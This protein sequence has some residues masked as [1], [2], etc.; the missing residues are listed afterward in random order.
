MLEKSESCTG[1]RG[2][3]K[4]RESKYKR[5]DLGQTMAVAM[6]VPFKV[7]QVGSGRHWRRG[8]RGRRLGWLSDFTLVGNRLAMSCSKVRNTLVRKKITW[9]SGDKAR[10]HWKKKN[11]CNLRRWRLELLVQKWR[12]EGKV[13]GMAWDILHPETDACQSI[14][15]FQHLTAGE[16]Q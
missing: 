16:A 15:P 5:E 12:H 2:R 9:Y 11:E 14:P 7:Q 6:R 10:L 13:R 8:R 3:V 1:S 4:V